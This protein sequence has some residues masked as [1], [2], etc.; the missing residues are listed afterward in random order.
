MVLLSGVSLLLANAFAGFGFISPPSTWRRSPGSAGVSR[1]TSIQSAATATAEAGTAVDE[2]LLGIW[3]YSGGAYEIRETDGRLFFIEHVS[4]ELQPEGEWLL[5]DLPTAG[6]IRLKLTEN[7]ELV[8]NFKVLGTEVWGDTITAVKDWETLT[9]NAK[10]LH[11]MLKTL[12]FE[13]SA[14]NGG[15]VVVVDGHQRPVDL[16]I[17]SEE[18]GSADL[19]DSIVAAQSAA[20]EVSQNA[21]TEKLRELYAVHFQQA[22]LAVQEVR[23]PGGR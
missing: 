3:R 4:G 15:V 8:S 9:G 5:A 14:A 1:P 22:P 18:A 17:S 11:D 7:G 20:A 10:A 16:R 19:G 2:K 12:E 13:G 21:Q 6:T 23:E